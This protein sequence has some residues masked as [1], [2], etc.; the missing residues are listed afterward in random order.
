MTFDFQNWLTIIGCPFEE[1]DDKPTLHIILDR[2]R[3]RLDEL[4]TLRATLDADTATHIW[5]PVF[6]QETKDLPLQIAMLTSH[7]L[8]TPELTP[9]PSTLS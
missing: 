5:D 1:F 7:P 2:L 8:M 6:A 4:T 9:C 3:S